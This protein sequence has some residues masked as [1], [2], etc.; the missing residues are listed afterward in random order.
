[1]AFGLLVHLAVRSI[2]PTR[3]FNS[4]DKGKEVPLS[5]KPSLMCRDAYDELYVGKCT[6]GLCKRELVCAQSVD[7]GGVGC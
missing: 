3:A 4:T 5:P 7:R 6:K 1:M 2:G